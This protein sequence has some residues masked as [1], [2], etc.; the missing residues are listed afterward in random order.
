MKKNVNLH[1]YAID[2]LFAYQN[3]TSRIFKDVIGLHHIH[4]IAVSH[5]KLF[6]SGDPKRSIDASY[7]LLTL[8]ST[9][10]LEFNLFN[11]PLWQFDRTYHPQWYSLCTSAAWDSLYMMEYYEKLYQLKQ[12][13]YHYVNSLSLATPSADGYLIFS[14]ATSNKLHRLF[15]GQEENLHKIGEYCWNL[16]SPLF[17]DISKKLQNARF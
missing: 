9:P 16:L 1:P 8:S 12:A 10:S 15:E 14:M 7:Q 3:Q 5:L 11:S 2:A 17:S 6:L 13:R 4:H